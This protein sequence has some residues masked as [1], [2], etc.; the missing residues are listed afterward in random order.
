MMTRHP[1]QELACPPWDEEDVEAK[2]R[3]DLVTFL[4][5]LEPYC[6]R[7]GVEPCGPLRLVITSPM[8]PFLESFA[9]YQVRNG[10][11]QLG[12]ARFVVES[13][14]VGFEQPYR[15]PAILQALLRGVLGYR[16]AAW[17]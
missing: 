12:S 6:P 15:R 17:G 2:W 3:L 5:F 9:L 10:V 7:G 14:E 11:L 16:T 4:R 13:V 1:H 8:V